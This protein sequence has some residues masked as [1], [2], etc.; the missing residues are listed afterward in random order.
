MPKQ[1]FSQQNISGYSPWV[2]HQTRCRW[3]EIHCA[4]RGDVAAREIPRLLREIDQPL[5]IQTCKALA[6]YF[7]PAPGSLKPGPSADLSEQW[8]QSV[9][10]ATVY[11]EELRR[12]GLQQGERGCSKAKKAACARLESKPSIRKLDIMLQGMGTMVEWSR[13]DW[14]P[15]AIEN[16]DIHDVDDID[17]FSQMNN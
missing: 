4:K 9:E 7:D 5:N 17:E 15:L 16:G 6:E 3:I 14:Q 2:Q 1:V 10:A 12:L 13:T 8:G 11:G